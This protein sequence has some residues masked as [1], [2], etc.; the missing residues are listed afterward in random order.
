MRK[1]EVSKFLVTQKTDLLGVSKP[2]DRQNL[3]VIMCLI[4]LNIMFH[5]QHSKK[6]SKK[7]SGWWFGTWL[8]FSHS[9]GND[10]TN[11][12][13]FFRGVLSTTNQSSTPEVFAHGSPGDRA[14]GLVGHGRSHLRRRPGAGHLLRTVPGRGKQAELAPAMGENS[15]VVFLGKFL[16]DFF[17]FFFFRNE[18]KFWIDVLAVNCFI[19][20]CEMDRIF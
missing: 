15:C 8:L 17:E 9:V 1:Y 20:R 2:H 14:G 3:L 16:G 5:H 6:S 18:G 12:L 4:Y 10:S 13:I 19:N 7:S 11:W